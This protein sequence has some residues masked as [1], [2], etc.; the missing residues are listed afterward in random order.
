M[1]EPNET[2]QILHIIRNLSLVLK[3]KV[4]ENTKDH[5]QPK[6]MAMWLIKRLEQATQDLKTLCK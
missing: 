2:N 5:V 1:S 6:E 3:G 4:I